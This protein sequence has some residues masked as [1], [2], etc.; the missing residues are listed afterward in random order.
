MFTTTRIRR[1]IIASLGATAITL[2][3]VAGPAGYR[4]SANAATRLLAVALPGYQVSLFA[5]GAAAYSRPDP[6]VLDGSH[7]YVAY[8]NNAAKDGTDR[9]TSTIVEY[10]LQ[11]QVVRTVAVPGH[12]DGMRLNP[13]SRQLWALSN[14]DGNPKLIAIDPMSGATQVYTFPS[15]PHGGGYDDLAFIHG[16]VYIDASNPTL[17]KAGINPAPALDTIALRGHSVVLTPVVMGDARA[18]DLTTNHMVT[19]NEVDPDSLSVDARG[20]VVMD[21]QA[22]SELIFVHNPGTARQTLTR[23]PLGTQVDDTAP[24]TAARGRLLVVDTSANAV[25]AVSATFT[26][27]TMYSASPNDSGVAG[28]VGTVDMKT[29]II[30][31]AIIGLGSPHGMAF[32]PGA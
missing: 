12:C 18:M 29:G 6:I 21:N 23:L 5:A 11:G 22:G 15:T 31:P 30:T 17:N 3:L 10:T 8:A 16:V 20:D 28:F 24:A 1:G 14:E 32:V 2:G 27:G 4:G 25:Y 13:V 9:R 26:P 7:V 19:L